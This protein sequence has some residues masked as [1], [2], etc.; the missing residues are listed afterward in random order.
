MRRGLNN[1]ACAE[2]LLLWFTP[3]DEY[4]GGDDDDADNGM[5]R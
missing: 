4:D 3:S 5:G 2:E 1:C